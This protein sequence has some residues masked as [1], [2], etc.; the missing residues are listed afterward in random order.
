[1][2]NLRGY[3]LIHC[4]V[5]VMSVTEFVLSKLTHI[6]TDSYIFV[7]LYIRDQSHD[8][9]SSTFIFDLISLEHIIA[10]GG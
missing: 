7:D 5:M 3:S 8:N 10:I 6:C 9:S 1:M 2:A 4:H